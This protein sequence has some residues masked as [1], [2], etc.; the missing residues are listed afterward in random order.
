[1]GSCSGFHSRNSSRDNHVTSSAL[2]IP[3]ANLEDNATKLLHNS[4]SSP[5]LLVE[6]ENGSDSSEFLIKLEDNLSSCF[7][8]VV[9]DFEN[10]PSTRNDTPESKLVSLNGGHSRQ[11][12]TSST[13]DF[14]PSKLYPEERLKTLLA[15]V[16]LATCLFCTTLALATVHDRRPEGPPLPDVIFSIVPQWDLG[17][18]I[19]EYLIMVCV[20][21]VIAMAAFHRFRWILFRRIFTIVGILYLGRAVTMLVTAVPVANTNY[22]CAPKMNI[23][24]PTTILFRAWTLMTGFGLSV[25]GKHIFC[26][27]YIYSG[28]TCMLVLCSLLYH[29][30][31]PRKGWL[32]KGLRAVFFTCAA[33]GVILVTIS[34]GHYTVDVIIAYCVTTAV[35]HTYH[36]IAAYSVLK[37][38][39]QNNHLARLW[40]FRLLAY[41]EE[42]VPEGKLPV[43]FNWP[44]PW[45]QR[46]LNWKLDFTE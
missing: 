44:L 33:M 11:L 8:N 27:D 21:P 20:Y 36:T 2:Y 14:R 42:N 12:S 1:M 6:S 3:L 40:F 31:L 5:S 9:I 13:D 17:L 45:P 39:S 22:F 24:G 29:E 10:E 41:F 34:R 25:N 43:R 46:Y 28:H 4:A 37:T 30:Y 38:N 18:A 26:G 35:F 16:F 23:T 15:F 7:R 32:V 19:S